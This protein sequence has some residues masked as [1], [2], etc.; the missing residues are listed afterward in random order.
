MRLHRQRIAREANHDSAARIEVRRGLNSRD[1]HNWRRRRI[2]VDA[3]A[4]PERT[5]AHGLAGARINQPV[6]VVGEGQR[7]LVLG[8][9]I[10]DRN[11]EERDVVRIVDR[12]LGQNQL[13]EERILRRTGRRIA[14]RIV[15]HK[16]VVVVE[17][18]ID[19]P[20]HLREHAADSVH[21]L[22][23]D[24]NDLRSQIQLE[25]D[26]QIRT[27]LERIAGDVRQ[28]VDAAADQVDAI[29]V[30]RQRIHEP[31]HDFIREVAD[32]QK[33]RLDR[34]VVPHAVDR[35]SEHAVKTATGQT[36]S[37]Q[38]AGVDPLALVES[39]RQIHQGIVTRIAVVQKTSATG[40]DADELRTERKQATVLE[41]FHQQLSQLA[42]AR[43]ARCCP[44]STGSRTVR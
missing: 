16:Q 8:R 7:R 26:L 9:R 2:L 33:A 17:I 21:R 11:G 43:R 44:G 1:D 31:H 41:P 6:Q 13:V 40:A 39:E 24:G 37:V 3:H 29:D 14:K 30:I 12:V 18:D 36:D 42:M 10:H 19:L 15:F 27:V 32:P 5:R 34:T 38:C 22:R 25:F 35:I 20:G 28:R 4:Q 23:N